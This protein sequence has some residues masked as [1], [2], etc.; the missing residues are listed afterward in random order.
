MPKSIGVN[1]YTLIDSTH[2][3]CLDI[4]P[5]IFLYKNSLLFYVQNI[6]LKYIKTLSLQFKAETVRRVLWTWY[7][8]GFSFN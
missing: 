8:Y 2:Q 6:T 3:G 7:L 5:N 1:V 4:N